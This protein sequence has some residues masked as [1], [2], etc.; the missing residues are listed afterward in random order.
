VIPHRFIS[1]FLASR[2]IQ[3]DSF[4]K[5]DAMPEEAPVTSAVPLAKPAD[6]FEAAFASMKK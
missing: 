5:T 3:R 2:R 4:I 1:D 6:D